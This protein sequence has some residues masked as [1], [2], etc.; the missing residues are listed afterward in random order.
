MTRIVLRKTDA[1]ARVSTMKRLASPTTDR[2]RRRARRSRHAIKRHRIASTFVMALAIMHSAVTMA[3]ALTLDQVRS[4]T[5]AIA[6]GV[7]SPGAYST[8]AASSS[9]LI[10]IG[11]GDQKTPL[12]RQRV[13]PDHRKLI[14]N[15]VDVT[16]AAP[17]STPELFPGGS[18]GPLIGAPI[19]GYVDL[20]SARYWDPAWRPIIYRQIDDIVAAG[21]DGIF[22]DVLDGFARWTP[23]N[24]L[25]NPPYPDAAPALAG[26]LK[27]IRAHVLGK[28]LQRPFYLLGN[29][30]AA[31]AELHPSVIADIDAVFQEWTFWGQPADNGLTSVYM[32]T[33]GAYQVRGLAASILK[34]IRVFGND[35]PNPLTNYDAAWEVFS[36]YSALGWTPSVTTAL[37]DD[38]V[39]KSGPFMFMATATNATVTGVRDRKNFLSGGNAPVATLIGGD[40]GDYFIGGARENTIIAGAGDDMIYA[41][42]ENVPRK[43]YLT[44]QLVAD[45]RNVADPMVSVKINGANALAATA[46][47]ATFDNGRIQEIGIDTTAFEPVATIEIAVSGTPY[48]DATHYTNVQLQGIGYQG[49]AVRFNDGVYANGGNPLSGGTS[50]ILNVG[51]SVTFGSPT[52]PRPAPAFANASNSID[53]GGGVN[54]VVYRESASNYDVQSHADGSTTVTSFNTN[55]GPDTLRNVQWLQFADVKLKLGDLADG[56]VPVVEYY[57]AAFDHYFV[58]AKA[59]EIAKLDGGVFAGWARTGLTF[60]AHARATSGALPVCRFFSTAFGP[61]S[62]HFYTP[63]ADECADVKANPNWQF[64]AA[65]DDTFYIRVAA[66]DGTCAPGTTPIYRLYNDGQGGA[67]NHRYTTDADTRSVMMSQGWRLEGNGPGFAFMCAP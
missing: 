5:Y 11:G 24:G 29:N 15:Y 36:F 34:D 57:H 49:A 33:M 39:F 28:H 60:N 37:Q 54:T 13:D 31:L 52:L 64:E 23:G 55:E 59:D 25:G 67:P 47:T 2:P 4:F 3:A 48:V 61:K 51:S 62:S 10:L 40:Q 35:Y 32:G 14:F 6:F 43:N 18:K 1:D 26:L 63:F 42:P 56:A 53:G 12:D 7:N 58:T 66:A 46:V 30:P 27:D 38:R 20:Y 45:T 19:P 44:I 22:L 50:A 9:D 21:Y 8:M 17:W 65:G 16:E 41:H